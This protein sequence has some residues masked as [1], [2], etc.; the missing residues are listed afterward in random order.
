[1][2]NFNLVFEETGEVRPPREREWFRGLD[3]TAQRARFDFSV[4]SFPILS[5]RVVEKP[6]P[7]ATEP[8][9]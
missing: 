3:G 4:Q 1:M 2:G 9:K 5:A 8:T 6:L 7:P